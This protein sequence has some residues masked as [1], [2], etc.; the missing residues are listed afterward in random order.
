MSFLEG[1][2]SCWDTDLR[3]ANRIREDFP[4]QTFL[5]MLLTY[6]ALGWAFTIYWQSSQ[7]FY[8]PR[9]G[10][11]PNILFRAFTPTGIIQFSKLRFESSLPRLVVSQKIIIITHCLSRIVYVFEF[12]LHFVMIRQKQMAYYV[13]LQNKVIIIWQKSQTKLK[14][15]ENKISALIPLLN[16]LR[17]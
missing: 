9:T 2:S 10:P 6:G 16:G 11:W 13:I 12:S 4:P 8:C 14:L 1:S 15:E 3:Y 5:L 17:F 7:M